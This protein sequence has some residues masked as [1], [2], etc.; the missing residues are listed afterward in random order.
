MSPLGFACITQTLPSRVRIEQEVTETLNDATIV[1]GDYSEN[2]VLIAAP[3]PSSPSVNFVQPASRERRPHS[4]GAKY[5]PFGGSRRNCMTERS[6][7][8]GT[9]A[10]AFWCASTL[11]HTSSMTNSV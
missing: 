6:C 9:A 5:S 8:F 4:V 1:T 2:G 7:S 11:T 3:L 10:N